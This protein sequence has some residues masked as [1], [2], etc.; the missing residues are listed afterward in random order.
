MSTADYP[1]A[2]GRDQP[3]GDGP[4]G[5]AADRSSLP[6]GELVRKLVIWG[7]FLALLYLIR[8]FFF[9]AF[10]TFLFSY[11]AL[12]AVDWIMGRMPASRNGLGVRRLV[13]LG[14]FVVAPLALLLVGLVVMPRLVVQGQRFIGWLSRLSPEAE[15]ARLVEGYVGP[16]EFR[17]QFGGPDDARYQKALA[18]FRATG[19]THVAAYLG[20]PKLEAWVEGSFARPFAD[21]QAARIKAR[22]IGEGTSS[23]EFEHW[24]LT[25]AAPK[26]QAEA[27]KEERDKGR[28]AAVTDSL[29]RAAATASPEQLL[30]QA[31]RE[32]AALAALERE[33]AADTVTAELAAAKQSPAYR[34]QVREHYDELRQRSPKAL[35][36]TYDQYI[37]LQEARAKGRR[38]FGEAMQAIQPDAPAEAD[39]ARRADFEAAKEHDLFQSWWGAS[40]LAK[41]VR[42]QLESGV[43]GGAAVQAEHY[44]ASTL[45]VPLDLGTAL[46][47]SFFICIDFPALRR[48]VPRLRETWLQPVYDELA[49][50]LISLG[51]LVGRALRA[52]GLIALCNATLM[53]LAL[54]ILG[55]EHAVMLATAVFVLCLV[56]TLGMIIAW[57]LLAVVALIQPGGGPGLVLKVSAA[58]AVVVALETFIFSPRILGKMME[59]HPVLIIALLP[60]AQYFFGVWGLILATPVAVFVIHE[61]ILRTGLPGGDARLRKVDR[62]LRIDG[63]AET[64]NRY[65][66]IAIPTAAPPVVGGTS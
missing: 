50:A 12:A 35:P 29:V 21:A 30:Q 47:L 56:P 7:L 5:E 46:L 16:A 49:P 65:P 10:F 42:Q 37:A 59:L 58:V 64:A 20:F 63:P 52:Q 32:P 14:V 23:K 54:T 8:D 57:L 2:I 61:V 62:G 19:E 6:R 48:A 39:A 3:P 11:L 45:D 51:S 66:Q 13:T 43:G 40:S 1:T 41:V 53:F 34:E 55:V 18:E 28:P 38:G 33:W 26:L 22:L 9:L 25:T 17:Q 44:L 60:V 15:I 36:Y 31:R 4:V 24:F 27:K